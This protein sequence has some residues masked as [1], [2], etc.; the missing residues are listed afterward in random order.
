MIFIDYFK[1]QICIILSLGLF[2]TIV[3]CNLTA[4]N[5]NNLVVKWE[6]KYFECKPKTTKFWTQLK[7]T[8]NAIS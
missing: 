7:K 8:V 5:V 2:L 6:K 3:F 1:T 4:V